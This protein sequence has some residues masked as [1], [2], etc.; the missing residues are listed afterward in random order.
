VLGAAALEQRQTQPI[1]FVLHKYVSW[2]AFY[3]FEQSKKSE[4]KFFE[5]VFKRISNK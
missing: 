5:F 2:N 3:M 4:N 1:A